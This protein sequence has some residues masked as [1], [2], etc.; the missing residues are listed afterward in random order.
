MNTNQ[1]TLTP[2][3]ENLMYAAALCI[4]QGKADD[5]ILLYDKVIALMPDYANAYYERGRA[6]HL[7]GDVLGASEDLKRAFQLSP[8][9]EKE[10]TASKQLNYHKGCK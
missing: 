1:P 2:V 7:A 8:E 9:L 5:A 4:S 6:R 10:I 3:T